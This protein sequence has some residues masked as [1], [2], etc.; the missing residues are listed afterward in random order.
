MLKVLLDDLVEAYESR[1]MRV[2]HTLQP[3]LTREA[4][5]EKFSW[6]RG[7]LPQ[8]LFELYEWRGGQVLEEDSDA[9]FWFRDVLFLTP[10]RARRQYESMMGTYGVD[11]SLE[12]DG[13]ELENCVP[14]G[15]YSGSWYVIPSGGQNIRP[16]YPSAIINVYHGVQLLYYSMEHMVRTCI[17]WVRHPDYTYKTWRWDHTEIDI[18]EEINPGIFPK[19][20]LFDGEA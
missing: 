20:S 2:S 18:W 17:K 1:D 10:E 19:K 5:V 11:S 6:F 3:G 4:I 8:D 9:P 14:F 13:L 7:T 16:E 12:K 15:A